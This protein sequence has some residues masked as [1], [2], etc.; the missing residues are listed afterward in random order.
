MSKQDSKPFPTVTCMIIADSRNKNPTYNCTSNIKGE[1]TVVARV[2]PIWGLSIFEKKDGN[3][4]AITDTATRWFCDTIQEGN[5]YKARCAEID[6]KQGCVSSEKKIGNK[7][8]ISGLATIPMIAKSFPS[9]IQ[10]M[11]ESITKTCKGESLAV[12]KAKKHRK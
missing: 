6:S 7:L 4:Q 12:A 1:R 3:L 2:L 11:N 5:A 10:A 9:D 8:I